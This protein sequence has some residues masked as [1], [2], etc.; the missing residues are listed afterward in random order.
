MKSEKKLNKE[1]FF[2]K[3]KPKQNKKTTKK[4]LY[5]EIKLQQKLQITIAKM[6][7][8]VQ[9]LRKYVLTPQRFVFEVKCNLST[10]K[11]KVF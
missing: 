9:F 6:T 5:K 3:N 4:T 8:S 11:Y 7:T 10:K 2:K 1:K